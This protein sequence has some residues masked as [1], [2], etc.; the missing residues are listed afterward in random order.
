MG[1]CVS[2]ITLAVFP[3]QLMTKLIRNRNY[4]E[5]DSNFVLA[6]LK[7]IAFSLASASVPVLFSIRSKKH[8]PVT[9]A[10][11]LPLKAYVRGPCHTYICLA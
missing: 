11:L 3:H 5:S 7:A 1:F 10:V 9:G 6:S 4:G 2:C 8:L